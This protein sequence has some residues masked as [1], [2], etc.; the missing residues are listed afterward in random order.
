[1][2][3]KS[4]LAEMYAGKIYASRGYASR[5][6]AGKI[7]ASRGTYRRRQVLP[8]VGPH[9]PLPVNRHLCR[10]NRLD[11]LP[12]LCVRQLDRGD[13]SW[14]QRATHLAYFV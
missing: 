1:M 5:G 12:D 13:S 9:A 2:P 10:G 14:V 6:Y 3:V 7:Y 8:V 11:F 4:I